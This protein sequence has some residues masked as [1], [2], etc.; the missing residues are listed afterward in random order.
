MVHRQKITIKI[1]CCENQS[2]FFVVCLFLVTKATY[3]NSDREECKIFCSF[4]VVSYFNLEGFMNTIWP[5]YSQAK[6]PIHTTYILGKCFTST[7]SRVGTH[8]NR[9]SDL[10]IDFKQNSW[11]VRVITASHYYILVGQRICWN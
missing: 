1:M 4:V 10:M 9:N 8:N 7:S 6:H 5:L 11:L 3:L 2:V